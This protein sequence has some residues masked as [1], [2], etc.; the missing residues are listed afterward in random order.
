MKHTALSILFLVHAIMCSAQDIHFSQQWNTP[1]RQNPALTGFFDGQHRGLIAYRRQWAS[2]ASPYRTMG[3]SYD[4]RIGEE[5]WDRGS[6]GIGTWIMR[7]AAG[8]LNLATTNA[9]LLISSM[10]AIDK[11]QTLSFGLSAGYTSTSIDPTGMR[12]EDPTGSSAAG[13]GI[14]GPA[15]VNLDTYGYVDI[16][17]GVAYAYSIGNST[18]SSN[19]NEQVLVGVSVS[20]LNRPYLEM[21][22]DPNDRIHPRLTAHGMAAVGFKNKRTSLIPS[23]EAALQGPSREITAGALCRTHLSEASRY[24]RIRREKSWMAGGYVRLGDAVIPAFGFE[25]NTLRVFYSYD[26]NVSRLR[27]ASR[28]RG[29]SEISL[30]F[31]L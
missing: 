16:S 31:T 5:K 14:S 10:L 19:D 1:L 26:I 8:D 15:Q 27:P 23:F 25:L 24:T 6:L 12:W 28:W 3:F 18:L 20:H 9:Q 13:G 7:D 2:V 11:R 29:G 4:S 21:G 30:Q 22:T 17:A